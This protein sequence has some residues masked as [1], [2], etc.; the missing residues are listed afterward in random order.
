MWWYENVF[1]TFFETKIWMA[2][3]ENTNNPKK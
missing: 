1:S 3:P 2:I